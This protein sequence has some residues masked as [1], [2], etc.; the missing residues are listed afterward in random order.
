LLW[1]LTPFLIRLLFH[2]IIF[3]ISYTFYE[4]SG[5]SSESIH[6]CTYSYNFA[7][8]SRSFIPTRILPQFLDREHPFNINLS[9][10]YVL[11]S[12][13]LYYL[14]SLSLWFILYLDSNYQ[15]GGIKEMLKRFIIFK[16]KSFFP[17]LSSGYYF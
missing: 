15:R 17:S 10:S 16:R 13:D 3:C 6:R 5:L 2:N 4:T 1:P 9:N 11:N 7:Y 12:N 8:N 14:S